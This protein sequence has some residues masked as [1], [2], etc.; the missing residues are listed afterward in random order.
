MLHLFRSDGRARI[1][2]APDPLTVWASGQSGSFAHL[3]SANGNSA[4]VRGPWRHTRGGARVGR[5]WRGHAGLGEG[6]A[7]T[8]ASSP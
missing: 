6:R 4:A 3:A 2:Y 1:Y 8:L 5:R 7:R